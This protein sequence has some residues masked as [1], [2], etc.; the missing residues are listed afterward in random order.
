MQLHAELGCSV[1]GSLHHASRCKILP[2][3]ISHPSSKGVEA[4][5]NTPQPGPSGRVKPSMMLFLWSFYCTSVSVAAKMRCVG[6]SFGFSVCFVREM[7]IDWAPFQIET[8]AHRRGSHIGMPRLQSA[9]LVH[10]HSDRC[11]TPRCILLSQEDNSQPIISVRSILQMRYHTANCPTRT[12]QGLSFIPA[13]GLSV[14]S[15]LNFE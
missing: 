4:R 12:G 14:K 13:R 11:V 15:N 7:A 5:F 6:P 2:H 3:R 8:N 10:A 1:H 9:Y